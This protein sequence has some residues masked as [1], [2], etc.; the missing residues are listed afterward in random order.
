MTKRIAWIDVAKGL[1]I[2]LV[3]LGHSNIND[4]TAVVINSFHMAAFFVLSGITY[5]GEKSTFR[6]FFCKKF[7]TIIIPYLVFSLIMLV[8][9]LLKKILFR[10][11]TFDIISGVISIVI[12]ISGRSSTTVYGLWFFPCLFVAEIILYV[13]FYIYRNSKNNV[14]SVI[15]GYMSLCVICRGGGIAGLNLV[16]IIDILPIAVLYL[17]IG[18]LM[19]KYLDQFK[20]KHVFMGLSLCMVFIICVLLN[21]RISGYVFD[22]SS[23]HLGIVPL[24]IISGICGTFS[25]FAL[26]ISLSRFKTLE[27]IGK[28]S[29]YYYGLHYEI[30]G[31]IEKLFRTGYFQTIVTMSILYIVIYFYKSMKGNTSQK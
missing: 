18:I 15:L 24:Y 19:Q 9:L 11:Y 16:S 13:F 14:M 3:I 23:M 2:I 28:N 27:M 21:Y 6:E 8:Y 4:I 10:G 31:G 7:R 26:A 29:M 17:G 30:I 5:R 22:M 12:P 25:I 20:E 1:L